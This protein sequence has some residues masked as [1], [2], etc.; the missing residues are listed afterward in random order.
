[1]ITDAGTGI[2]PRGACVQGV[3]SRI[4]G[5]IRGCLC[6]RLAETRHLVGCGRL[7]AGELNRILVDAGEG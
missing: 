6:G 1:M 2:Q 3:L 4:W 7:V 5:V